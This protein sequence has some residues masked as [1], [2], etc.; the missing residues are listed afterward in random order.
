MVIAR[1]RLAIA[2]LACLT[3][4]AAA[5]ADPPTQDWTRT[6]TRADCAS[7]NALRTPFFGDLHV[8]TSFSGDAVFVRV[9]STPRDAYMFAKG[10]QVGLPPYDAS[11]NPTRFAQLHRPLDFTAVTDHAEWLGEIRTCLNSGLP[12][13]DDSNCQALRTEISSPPAGINQPLPAIVVAFQL[14][15]QA[16]DPMRLSMCGTNDVNCL[17]QA[18][19]VWQ[20]E[21]DAAEEF[22]DRTSACSFTT[23]PGYEWTN[24]LGGYNL[25]RNVIFRNADVPSLPTSYYDESNL[26]DLFTALESGCFGNGQCDFMTIPHNS[27]VSGGQMFS[28]TNSDGS[29]MTKADAERRASHEK[30]VEMFQN[31]GNS[32]CDPTGS[33]ND[34]FCG[35]EQLQRAQLFGNTVANIS[36]PA[37]S[38]VRRALRVGIQQHDL[39]GANP[40]E[41]GMIGSSDTHNGT[42]GATVETDY[43]TQGHLGV[44]DATPQNI[45]SRVAPGGIVTNGGGLAVVWAEE[46]SRDAIFSA[47]RRR[48]TYSTSGTRPIVRFFGGRPELAGCDDPNFVQEGYSRGVP[49]GGEIGPVLGR[50]S[51]RFAVMATQDPGGN[52]EPSTPLQRVQIVKGWVDETHQTHEQVFDVAGDTH[53][54]ASVDPSTCATSGPG[55]ATLCTTWTDPSFRPDERAFYYAR[56]L[57]NPVCRWSTRLCNSLGVDCSNPGSVPSQYAECCSGLVD[58]TIQ[59][60]A[61]TSPIYYQPEHIGVKGQIRFGNGTNNDQLRLEL[62]IGR[63]PSELDVKT[64]GLTLT[65]R[66]DDVI[67]TATLPAGAL[68]EKVPGRSYALVDPMGTIAGI[69]KARLLINRRGTGR[70]L[71]SANNVDLSHAQQTNHRVTTEL[72]S[73]TYDQSDDRVWESAS[74]RLGSQL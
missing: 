35:F 39:I 32:E 51:P 18:A 66:D 19:L 43:G 71:I 8:H 4:A 25:H 57:E 63:V 10:Q 58:K 54:D 41:L 30:V 21:L 46:N 60:R 73:G 23:F 36:L 28:P 24:N 11:D 31:K 48:E 56:V 65:M 38:F 6:E 44:R 3:S 45:L 59:E 17:T 16:A 5:W 9:R 68:V 22:Y 14:T 20:D 7:Y 53:G 40:F 34:E 2:V 64:N 70:L 61:W 13:Y 47:I 74:G 67:Y 55:S 1:F 50:H 37:Q 12:G 52:G 62:T 69:R 49:M 15:I 29:A 72:A 42:P 33:P 26:E 27:N